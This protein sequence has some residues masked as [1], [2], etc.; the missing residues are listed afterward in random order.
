M[1]TL[2]VN[3]LKLKIFKWINTLNV[4]QKICSGYAI[5]LSITIA[6][7]G[8]G[9][10]LGNFYNQQGVKQLKDSFEESQDF[11]IFLNHL[12]LLQ[13]YQYRLLE[14]T[15]QPEAF[16]KN[17]SLFISHNRSVSEAWSS[18]KQSYNN[19]TIEQG[20]EEIEIFSELQEN[21]DPMISKYITQTN[22]LVNI[23]RDNNWTVD[24][25]EAIEETLTQLELSLVDIRFTNFLEKLDRLVQIINRK[26]KKA[27]K[28][29]LYAQKA[30]AYIIIFTTSLSVII[31]T[32]LGVLIS[33]S[34]YHPLE[35]L[36][37]SID[38]AS[39]II[40]WLKSSGKFSYVNETARQFLGYSKAEFLD[41]KF[42][43]I[44]V[45]TSSKHW[46]ELWQTIKSQESLL[47][48]SKF[49]NKE[50]KTFAVEINLNYLTVDN[51]E[52]ACAIVRDITER[53][54]AEE[55]IEK[56]QA[57]L[58]LVINTL[59]QFIFWKDRNSVYF[60]CNERFAKVGGL[61]NP[62]QIIG[63]TDYDLAWKKE[64]SDFYR[65][66]DRE[67]MESDTSQIGIIEPLLQADGKQIWL[68]TKLLKKSGG[69]RLLLVVKSG[70]EVSSAPRLSLL[71][72]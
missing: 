52:Y 46:K 1:K 20:K 70:I 43:D 16:T 21:Y 31:A 34:I 2:N 44:D 19:S 42:E 15:N 33:Q 58:Q 72:C 3:A 25:P 10:S 61:D 59:P 17:L 12:V 29:L 53:K 51:Q 39:D 8:I 6:G 32:I 71:D 5:V 67:V 50:G 37:Y 68:E 24:N 38:R 9:L 56:S 36:K 64:E 30:Q 7:V 47:I 40:F 45:E 49:Q 55:K 63:K 11:Q 65:Q 13:S 18:L 28:N 41:L 26:H 23:I 69:T 48:E 22:D 66:C 62:Q 57:L 4:T 54:Q 27:Q 60:G 14:T 35:T